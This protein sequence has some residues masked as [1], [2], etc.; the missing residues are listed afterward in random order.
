MVTDCATYNAGHHKS[1]TVY[2]DVIY[3]ASALLCP[4]VCIVLHVPYLIN[5]PEG[6]TCS[7]KVKTKQTMQSIPCVNAEVH[8]LVLVLFCYHT[9]YVHT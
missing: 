7:I 6:F 1:G 9:K 4:V 8:L 3:S 5:V 2:D